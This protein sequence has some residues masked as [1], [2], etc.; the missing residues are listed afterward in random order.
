MKTL[1]RASGLHPAL[2]LGWQKVRGGIDRKKTGRAAEFL[3]LQR[4]RVLWS[5]EGQE[6]LKTPLLRHS[7]WR[8]R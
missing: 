7:I 1:E 8:Q 2:R 3:S 6:P 4:R 5:I